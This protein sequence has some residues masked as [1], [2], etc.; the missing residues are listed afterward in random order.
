MTVLHDVT[1]VEVLAH[2]KLRLTFD[3]GMV[4]DVDLS[5]LKDLTG[6][7]EQ[8]RDPKVFAQV[9]VDSEAGTI[10]WPNGLDLDPESLYALV[11]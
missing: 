5:H 10:T 8:L 9:R 2:Y 3:D 11:R 7:Y 1:A 4:G 6:V